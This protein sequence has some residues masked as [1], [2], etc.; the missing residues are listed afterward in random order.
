MLQAKARADM[1]THKAA[2]AED[3]NFLDCGLLHVETVVPSLAK[4]KPEVV[5]IF[6]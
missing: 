4:E 1:S 2:A 6:A 3:Q 5:R